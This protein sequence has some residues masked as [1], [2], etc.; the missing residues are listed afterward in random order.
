VPDNLKTVLY[1]ILQEAFNNVAKYSGAD[2]AKIRLM[3]TENEITLSIEDNGQGFDSSM[4]GSARR[5]F[6]LTSMRE[7]AELSGGTLRIESGKGRGTRIL[8]SWR[9]HEPFSRG[10]ERL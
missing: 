10:S 2:R 5:G 6:G 3:G 7:R 4:A 1:R 9:F 8:A